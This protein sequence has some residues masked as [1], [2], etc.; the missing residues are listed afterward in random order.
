MLIR[1]TVR[2]LALLVVL[3]WIAPAG[4]MFAQPQPVPVDRLVNN[5]TAYVQAHPKDAEGHYQLGRVHYLAFAYK[6]PVVGIYGRRQTDAPPAQDLPQLAGRHAEE[7]APRAYE[8]QHP[9]AEPPTEAEL[10]AHVASA[11]EHL[12]QALELDP[13][14]ALY[15][16]TYASLLE[17]AAP[18]AGKL[19]REQ[20]QQEAD[21]PQQIAASV[22]RQWQEKA[23]AHYLT[24]YQQSIAKDLQQQHRPI[25]G[26]VAFTSYEA[27]RGY[28]RLAKQTNA[29]EAQ[30]VAQ[31][32]K[33]VAQLHRKPIGAI[34]PIVFSL[35]GSGQTLSDHLASDT[36]VTF[37][38]DGTGRTQRWS[39][40][41]PDTALLVW[42]PHG[43]GRITSGR[44][45]FGSVTWWLFWTDGYHALAALDDDHNGEL[46][47]AEL[48]GIAAWFDR[49]QNGTSE[50]GEVTPVTKLGIEAIACHATGREGRHPMHRQGLRLDDGTTRPT[51][52][53]IA[54]PID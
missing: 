21:D 51:W 47:G 48:H 7:W 27:G 6:S 36:R 50:P 37:N 16:L 3:T 2:M 52:D 12:R 33:G 17:Q 8:R 40:V 34:T 24:A 43:T 1:P 10:R 20:Q 15:H 44:Q 32:R 4:A 41:Q 29:A 25:E 9:D 11:G 38:L 26:L 30:T 46:A 31:V 42:D 5:I 53:W 35:E 23:L 54:R 49:N 28:L 39:W 45:L 14:N 13:D 22:T 18:F 19:A